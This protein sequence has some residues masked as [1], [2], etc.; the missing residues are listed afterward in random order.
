MKLN[1][2]GIEAFK[3]WDKIYCAENDR[4]GGDSGNGEFI[5]GWCIIDD[6]EHIKSI[7]DESELLIY[8]Y[9]TNALAMIEEWQELENATDTTIFDKKLGFTFGELKAEINKYLEE[10]QQ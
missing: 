1:Q 3:K 2:K 10:Y 9:E 8:G 6:Y 4:L 7:T 5:E